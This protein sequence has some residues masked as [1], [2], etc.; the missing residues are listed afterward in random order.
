MKK[1]AGFSI[2]DHNFSITKDESGEYELELGNWS[3]AGWHWDGDTSD[4][5]GW[6]IRMANSSLQSE[7][8]A[9]HWDE[10]KQDALN[11]IDSGDWFYM[12]SGD[13]RRWHF[14]YDD[15]DYVY[16][17]V[18]E[19]LNYSGIEEYEDLTDEQKEKI[20]DDIGDIGNVSYEEFKEIY[21]DEFKEMVVEA[22]QNSEYDLD[23]FKRELGSVKDGVEEVY[24]EMLN[25][26]IYEDLSEVVTKVK[27][28]YPAELDEDDERYNP[29]YIG[30]P[31]PKEKSDYIGDA[32]P[33]SYG[34][35]S[36]D[37]KQTKMFGMKKIR[38]IKSKLIKMSYDWEGEDMKDTNEYAEGEPDYDND[39]FIEDLVRGGYSVSLSGKFIGKVDDIEEG[40]LLIHQ[41]AGLNYFPSMWFVNERGNVS[42]L[43]NNGDILN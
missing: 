5:V 41:K 20:M 23:D 3:D 2:N 35:G 37:D 21:Y 33:D 19:D 7:E 28:E 32:K 38:Q 17:Q 14:G 16:T 24:Y 40:I 34:Y 10:I 6:L 29:D 27:E 39:A 36:Q 31:P 13:N 22:L 43:N 25:N 26:K 4:L 11:Q 1:Q 12:L 30:N 18:K 15:G 9:E 42:A 8:I